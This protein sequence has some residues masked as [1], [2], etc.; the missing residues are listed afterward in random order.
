MP[1]S[2]YEA[3]PWVLERER[4]AMA[5]IAPDMAWVNIGTVGGWEGMVPTWPFER[6]APEPGLSRLLDGSRL[7][8]RIEYRQ[9]HPAVA[10]MV[11][12]RAPV[13]PREHRLNHSWHLNGDGT[14]CLLGSTAHWRPS[15]TAA[16]VVIK[17]SGWYIEYLLKR[18][19]L[20][21]AMSENGL[22][23]DSSYDA[24]IAAT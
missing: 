3:Q 4:H 22:Y 20:I 12:P 14:L 16:E 19:G 13:P 6:A 11:Y 21:P 15:D 1:I 8:V 7:T 18:R 2:W 5:E 24:I 23:V 9:A 10:P 17:A